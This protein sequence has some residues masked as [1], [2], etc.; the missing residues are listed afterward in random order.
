MKE[1]I[2]TDLFIKI[3]LLTG[4]KTTLYHLILSDKHKKEIIKKLEKIDFG[5]IQQISKGE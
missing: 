2:I 3:E 1:A 5:S 4:K